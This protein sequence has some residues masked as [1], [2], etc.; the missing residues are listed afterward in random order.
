MI[1][2][3]SGFRYK[4]FGFYNL[5]KIIIYSEYCLIIKAIATIVQIYQLSEIQQIR[6]ILLW[7]KLSR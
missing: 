6:Q 7:T 5:K 1:V 3:Q 4:I 2:F